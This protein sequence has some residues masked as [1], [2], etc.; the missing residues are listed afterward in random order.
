M[1]AVRLLARGLRVTPSEVPAPE[2][3]AALGPADSFAPELDGVSRCSRVRVRIPCNRHVLLAE[4]G[5]LRLPEAIVDVGP[6]GTRT[7]GALV[8][9]RGTRPDQAVVPS[10]SR[11]AGYGG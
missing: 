7:A 9:A 2:V 3:T 10:V 4:R 5:E 11:A 1:R 8:A 6:Y